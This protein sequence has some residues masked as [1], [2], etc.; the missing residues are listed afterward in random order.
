MEDDQNER[1]KIGSSC[2][3]VFVSSV[4]Y[5]GKHGIWD[6]GQSGTLSEQCQ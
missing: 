1:K 5:F 6:R 4:D 3:Y 2:L